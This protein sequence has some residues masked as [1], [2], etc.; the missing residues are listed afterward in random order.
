VLPLITK[1][2]Y[3]YTEAMMTH[4]FGKDWTNQV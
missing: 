3:H 4:I 1:T 2:N